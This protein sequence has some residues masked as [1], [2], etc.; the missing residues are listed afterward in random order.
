MLKLTFSA[1][2]WRVIIVP[3]CTGRSS[4]NICSSTG[5]GQ[6]KK[7]DS[8]K[9]SLPPKLLGKLVSSLLFRFVQ[10]SFTVTRLMPYNAKTDHSCPLIA[11]LYV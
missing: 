6:E 4:E 8:M 11:R 2:G 3:S 7:K 9:L 10:F 1:Q 5:G